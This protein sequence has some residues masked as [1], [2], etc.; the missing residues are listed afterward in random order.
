MTEFRKESL[1]YEKHQR[2]HSGLILYM[3]IYM[4]SSNHIQGKDLF[5]TI[6]TNTF[7][8]T[9][10]DVS[11]TQRGKQTWDDWAPIPRHR[12]TRP[13]TPHRWKSPTYILLHSCRF[14]RHA[15]LLLRKKRCV[16]SQ[17][18]ATKEYSTLY[19]YVSDYTGSGL[20]TS[21]KLRTKPVQSSVHPIVYNTAT[22]NWVHVVY[23]ISSVSSS[24]A[25]VISSAVARHKNRIR[26]YLK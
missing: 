14:G 25:S 20:Y 10:F 23:V 9:S 11:F 16:T 24:S 7:V 1:W 26:T 22:A 3:S 6:S 15:T 4:Y 8:N 17:V 19:E 2:L 13:L 18:T 5:C 21:S 12:N